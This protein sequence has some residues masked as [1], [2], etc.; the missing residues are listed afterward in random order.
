MGSVQIGEQLRLLSNTI[1]STFQN[2]RKDQD[3]FTAYN[4]V[5]VILRIAP[6]CV[7][8]ASMLLLS[9]LLSM[10]Q[11]FVSLPDNL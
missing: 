9:L 3:A 5:K 1:R 10:G 4:I 8:R 6:L 11:S 7:S 2:S